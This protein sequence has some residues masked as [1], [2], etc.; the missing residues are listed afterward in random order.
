MK[1]NNDF[2]PPSNDYFTKNNIPKSYPDIIEQV[3]KVINKYKNQ[4]EQ[5]KPKNIPYDKNYYYQ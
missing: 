1:N 3:D 4:I 5:L 2:I